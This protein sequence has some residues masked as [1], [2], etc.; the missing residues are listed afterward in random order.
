MTQRVLIS[1]NTDIMN[2]LYFF[3][4]E[5]VSRKDYDVFIIFQRIHKEKGFLVST[6]VGPKTLAI[7]PTGLP[8]SVTKRKYA[9]F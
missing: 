7:H 5:C 9:R 2:Q 3:F 6:R 8:Y 1:L 4:L